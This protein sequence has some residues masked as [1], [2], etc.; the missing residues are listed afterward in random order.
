MAD[1]TWPNFFIVGA[2]RSGTT[3]LYNYL[4]QMQGIYMS[5]LKEPC[6]FSPSI[7]LTPFRRF[8]RDK[9]EYLDLF[10]GIKTEKAIGEASPFYLWDPESP[11]LIYDSVPNARIIAIVPDPVERAYSSYLM[12]LNAGFETLNFIDA[13][14][15]NYN[16]LKQGCLRYPFYIELGFYGEQMERYLNRFGSG[17]IKIILF[18]DFI[19]NTN[20]VVREVARFLDVE[21]KS[22]Y[23]IENLKIDKFN[24]AST[25][26]R[27]RLTSHIIKLIFRTYH[28]WRPRAHLSVPPSIKR[29]IS[30]SLYKEASKP[31]MPEKAR[32]FLEGLY[33]EDAFK[34]QKLLPHCI[35]WVKLKSK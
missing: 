22:D 26:P 32:V 1:E 18:D 29:I 35:P 24:S 15:R 20:D 11:I 23:N 7:P 4:R 16:D 28:T 8:V 9:N 2:Q 5:P 6:F 3:S 34:L 25:I 27:S 12:N 13:I 33:L 31:Q 14:L 30:E 21:P 19:K 17:R 10:R